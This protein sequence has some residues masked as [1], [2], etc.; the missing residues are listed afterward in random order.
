MRKYVIIKPNCRELANHLWNYVSIYAYGIET[1][2]RVHNPSFVEWH[3]YFNLHTTESFLTRMAARFPAFHGVWKTMGVLYGS[4]LIRACARCVRLTLGIT[5]YLPP[6]R[7]IVT[8]G[9]A[10]ETTYFIGWHFRNPV[11]LER[12]RDA[13]VSAFMP[14][15][16]VLK[17]IE[18]ALASFRG[19]QLI[20]VHLRQRPYPGFEDGDFLVSPSRVRRIIDECLREKKW[21]TKNVALVIVSDKDVDLTAFEGFTT[22]IRCGNDVPALFLLSKCRV[23]IGTNSTFANLAAWFGNVP[24][25]VETNEPVDWE[26]YR[27]PTTYFENKYATLAQ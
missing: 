18:N 14:S 20:G 15:E 8:R 7:P 23:V 26:Y 13:L 2:A 25:I 3:R 1:G 10:C 6:T 4:Y 12:Y 9:G 21:E 5:M 22:H 16:S 19:K 24:H 17:E 11:G 27:D